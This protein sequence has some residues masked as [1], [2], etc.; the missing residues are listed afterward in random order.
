MPSAAAYAVTYLEPTP[1][2]SAPNIKD[3][4][5]RGRVASA[6]YALVQQLQGGASGANAQAYI[7]L[8]RRIS[9]VSDVSGAMNN[10]FILTDFQAITT[11]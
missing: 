11:P 7:S 8:S 1:A 5:M 10:T 3:S 2:G 9:D 6:L 4:Y